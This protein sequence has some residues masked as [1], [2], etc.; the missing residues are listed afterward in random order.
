MGTSGS[1]EFVSQSTDTSVHLIVTLTFEGKTAIKKEGLEKALKLTS[2]V[3][4]TNMVCFDQHGKIK[5]YNAPEEIIEDFYPKRLAFYQKRKVRGLC[6]G[7]GAGR[8]PNGLG[9]TSSPT[10][11]RRNSTSSTT[12]LASCR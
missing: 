5:K 11:W 8:G 12:R 2:S 10:S 3:A 9:R 7:F 4:T 1:Q 6:P